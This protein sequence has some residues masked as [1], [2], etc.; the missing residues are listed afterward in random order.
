MIEDQDDFELEAQTAADLAADA[1]A[2][3]TAGANWPA[4]LAQMMDVTCAALERGGLDEEQAEALARIAVIAQAHYIGG[5]S[6]YFPRGKTLELALRDDAIYRASRRGNTLALAQ[7]YGL[8][9]RAVQMIVKRQTLLHRA[10]MQ[11]C[12]FQA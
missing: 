12:L 10:R 4:T 2:S 7:Q 1:A 6:V 3:K 5:R 8:S 9:D 11:A